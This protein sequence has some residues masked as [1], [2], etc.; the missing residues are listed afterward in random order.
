MPQPIHFKAPHPLTIKHYPI[1]NFKS[2]FLESGSWLA[3]D[4]A[5]QK[6]KVNL[7][8][9]KVDRML[10][11]IR[12]DVFCFS[13]FGFFAVFCR[14]A[15]RLSDSIVSAILFFLSQGKS[16]MKME[17]SPE[18]HLFCIKRTKQSLLYICTTPCHLVNTLNSSP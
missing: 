1:N 8:C 12:S 14:A 11:S 17:T 18:L 6:W 2:C 10:C 13:F 9:L 16:T 7:I 3:E 5:Q 4:N 15:L